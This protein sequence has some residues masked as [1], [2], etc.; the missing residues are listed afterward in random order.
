MRVF[1]IKDGKITLNDS[2]TPLQIVKELSSLEYNAK[3]PKDS[4]G[5]DRKRFEAELKYVFDRYSLFSPYKSWREEDRIARAFE[6]AGF[7]DK[8]KESEQLKKFIT[9]VQEF[10]VNT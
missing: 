9:A 2:V 8:W 1:N 10:E 3:Y 4:D 6:N 7:P 5:R